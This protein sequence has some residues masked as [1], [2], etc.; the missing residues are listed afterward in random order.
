MRATVLKRTVIHP[1]VHSRCRRLDLRTLRALILLFFFLFVFLFSAKKS[2]FGCLEDRERGAGMFLR[3]TICVFSHFMVVKDFA[4]FLRKLFQQLD[5]SLRQVLGDVDLEMYNLPSIGFPS[6]QLL[7]TTLRH[8]LAVVRLRPARDFHGFDTMKQRHPH[9][10]SKSSL[11]NGYGH[12]DV[13]IWAVSSEHRVFANLNLN[14][15]MPSRATISACITLVAHTKLHAVFNARRDAYDHLS[16]VPYQSGT[17]AS[18]ANRLRD[19]SPAALP[20]GLLHLEEPLLENLHSRSTTP[21]A[22]LW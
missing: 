8:D 14:I 16:R 6:V 20:A 9:C 18:V 3:A 19:S 11:G 15:Q 13:D 7:D 17:L 10:S 5:L 1:N 12:I 21:A 22:R 2:I 4:A